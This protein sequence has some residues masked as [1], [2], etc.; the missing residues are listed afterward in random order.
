MTLNVEATNG[1]A[2]FMTGETCDVTVVIPTRNRATLLAGALRSALSQ[3]D[4]SFEVRV[5]DDASTDETAELLC[6]CLD[7]RVK[8]VRHESSLGVAAARNRAVSEA[9]GEWLAF[10]DDD[11]LWSP[12]WLR[13]ALET[14][15]T[16]KAGAVYGSRWIIDDCRRVKDAWPAADA[17]Q[18]RDALAT[19]NVFGGPSGVMVRADVIAAAG[20]FDERLSALADWEMWLRVLEVCH[21]APVPDFLI[22]YTIHSGNMHTR[23][24][25]G[26]LAEFD[27]FARILKDREGTTRNVDEAR[28]V[29][30]LAVEATRAGLRRTAAR[31]WLRSARIAHKPEDVVR[32][33]LALTRGETVDCGFAATPGWISAL[34]HS[35]T[36]VDVSYSL[37]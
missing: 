7:T 33:G 30:W 31:L 10:L 3:V 29:R 8:P 32:A 35:D 14:A 25:F 18:V 6:N 36:D 21:A 4:V 5:V 23:D 9:K 37:L 24:P 16:Q 27:V 26:Y 20:E 12:T 2:G 19:H 34:G 15:R 17:S 11:D 28:F 1:Q 22:A 13:T